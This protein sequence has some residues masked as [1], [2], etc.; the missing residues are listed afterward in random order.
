[1][2]VTASATVPG[3]RQCDAAH[4]VTCGQVGPVS[5]ASF[6]K[7]LTERVTSGIMDDLAV[8]LLINA[9]SHELFSSLTTP[10]QLARSQALLAPFLAPNRATRT[11]LLWLRTLHALPSDTLSWTC[12]SAFEGAQV[13]S[14]VAASEPLDP[15]TDSSLRKWMDA[16]FARWRKRYLAAHGCSTPLE[17]FRVCLRRVATNMEKAVPDAWKEAGRLIALFLV[18]R[19]RMLNEAIPVKQSS[20]CVV[21]PIGAH[22]P[23]SPPFCRSRTPSRLLLH[24]LRSAPTA[25]SS[26]SSPA[27]R[28]LRTPRSSSCPL[29]KPRAS[30]QTP[31][32]VATLLLC[33][34]LRS[35]CASA[36]H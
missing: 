36:S 6:V 32:L 3:Q 5:S 35:G 27:S 30:S 7:T 9:T 23:L 22:D 4:C 18:R 25:S 11:A 28:R 17:R 10:E 1:M 19:G 26:A 8:A 31:S 16:A 14:L 34:P 29:A 13:I 2:P 20:A 12:E 24:L 21:A 15:K 33:M